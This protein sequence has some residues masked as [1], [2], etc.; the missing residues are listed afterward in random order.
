L[1]HKDMLIIQRKSDTSDSSTKN[2]KYLLSNFL[3]A[4]QFISLM[5]ADSSKLT[6]FVLHIPNKI[7]EN[8]VHT[9][10]TKTYCLFIQ[11]LAICEKH[12]MF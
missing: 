1:L 3:V 7:G 9:Y 12:R 8:V 11:F 2:G 4:C 6:A 5:S 10:K